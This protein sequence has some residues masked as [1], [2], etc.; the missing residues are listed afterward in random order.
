MFGYQCLVFGTV[1]TCHFQSFYE[2]PI[3]TRFQ[4]TA[5]RAIVGVVSYT[6]NMVCKQIANIEKIQFSFKW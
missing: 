2:M 3:L 5:V 1:G 4:V 6:F